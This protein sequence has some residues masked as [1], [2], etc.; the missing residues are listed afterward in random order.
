MAQL[1]TSVRSALNE[2]LAWLQG[3]HNAEVDLLEDLR[4]FAR[5]RS[6]MEK[7]YAE[8]SKIQRRDYY[9]YYFIYFFK[10]LCE[11]TVDKFLG[12]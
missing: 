12:V 3:K 7:Q 8:V 4:H 5:Q 9:Y 6:A 11:L 2:Q 1:S 10:L